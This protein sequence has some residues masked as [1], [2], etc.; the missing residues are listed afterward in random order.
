MASVMVPTARI[1]ELLV[2]DLDIVQVG[3]GLAHDVGFRPVLAG[4]VRFRPRN[5]DS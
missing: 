5:V 3:M 1:V 2:N 4:G